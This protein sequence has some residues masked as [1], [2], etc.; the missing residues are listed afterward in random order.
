MSARV[1]VLRRNIAAEEVSLARL[2]RDRSEAHDRLVRLRAELERESANDSA[3]PTPVPQQL[4]L[5]PA[6]RTNAEK[7]ALFRELFRGR[8]DV[9]PTRF[10]SRQGKSGYSPACRNK[11]EPGLCELPK[12]K[13][14]ECRNQ[15][16]VPVTDDAISDHLRGQHVMGVYPMLPDHTCWFLAVDFDKTTWMA[17]VRAFVE[18][19]RQVGVPTLVERSR[20][21]NGAHVWFFFSGPLAASTA[22]K[23]GCYLV[24]ETMARRHE[25]GMDSYDR[26][27][28]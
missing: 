16:F 14:G 15:A 2:E 12:V 6:P 8:Q 20:S 9:F 27:R 21:G 23:L 4:S 10:E 19:C 3:A 25:L 24:T 7:V 11:F 13:C 1:E 26:L 18:T 5:T 22:R 28:T 17:D